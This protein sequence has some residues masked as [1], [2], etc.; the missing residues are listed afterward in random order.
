MTLAH[1]DLN[2][3]IVFEAVMRERSVKKASEKLGLSQP[4]VSHALNRMRWSIKDQLFVRTPDGMSPTPRAEQLSQPIRDALAGLQAALEPETFVPSL[5]QRRFS[6]AVN[7][8]A[9]VVLA[10]PIAAACAA[11]APGVELS[12]RPSGNLELTALLD[13]GELDLAIS[14]LEIV[15]ERFASALLVEDRYVAAMRRG[16][17]AIGRTLDIET[18]GALPHLGISSSGEDMRFLDLALAEAGLTRHV[19][20]EV[21][22][23]AAGA[24]LIQSDSVAVLGRQLAYEFR[25]A[26]A[27]ELADLPLQSPPLRS[28]MIWPRRLDS[29]PAHQWL[30]QTVA[31]VASQ[32]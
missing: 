17:P 22:Y 31:T 25:R 9:A 30:R 12:L 6:I 16:H 1:F 13:R 7:N 10:G 5:T 26:Y 18:L 4:A 27:I 14:S 32:L 19:T 2:L 23:L 3:L 11:L 24:V 21:P 29:Q 28:V 15:G 20:L 8:Y